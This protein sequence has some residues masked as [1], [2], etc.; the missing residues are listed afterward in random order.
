[1]KKIFLL[2]LLI[3]LV[4]IA[5]FGGGQ[6]ITNPVKWHTSVEKTGENT[7]NLIFEADIEEGWHVYS[8]FN[9]PM[10]S[11]P[12]EFEW[13][14]AKGNYEVIGKAKE[15]NTHK[16][17]NK[18]FKVTETFFSK[19]AKLSQ[20]IKLINKNLKNIKV[21][22]F[23]QTCK[24]SCI[25]I[26]EKLSFDLSKAKDVSKAKTDTNTT[27]VKPEKKQEPKTDTSNKNSTSSQTEAPKENN[28]NDKVEATNKTDETVN[29][30]QKDIT[31]GGKY[32][33][34]QIAK[35]N[36]QQEEVATQETNDSAPEKKSD[37]SIFWTA[38]IAGLLVLLTPCVFPMIPLTISFFTKQN[39]NSSKGK[40]N[41]LVYAF[42]IV[43][44]Y[45]AVSLP[46]HLLEKADS[47]IFN[48][49]AT[50]TTVNLVF[51]TIFILFALNLFGVEKLDPMRLVPNSWVS[52]AD[53]R[54]NKGGILSGFFMALTLVIVSFSCTGP[55]LG[56]ILGNAASGASG[57]TSLTFALL[58]FGLGI[59]IPFGVLAFF[60]VLLQKL[61]QSGAWLNTVKVIFG[62]IELAFAFKFLSNADLVNQWHFLHRELFIAIWV[63]ISLVMAMYLFG[64]I[65][66][67]HDAPVENISVFR[68][69]FGTSILIFAIYLLPG[70]WG[71]PLNIISG[72]PPPMKYAESKFGV[73]N[74][75]RAKIV[76]SQN[77]ANHKLPEGAEYGPNNIVTFEDYDLA[78]AHAKEVNKPLL[79]DFTGRACQNCR[80]MEENVWSK[81][82][83][84]PILNNEVVLVSLFVDE[85]TELPKD[86]QYISK[87]TGDKVTTVGK[88]WSEMET[89]VYKNNS[90]PLY[91][92]VDHDEKI[93]NKN[94]IGYTPEV[95]K[96]YEWLRKGID[97]FNKK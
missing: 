34:I 68:F 94:A 86:K 59:A 4:S 44:I 95:E 66:L 67:P 88:K 56:F 80:L 61:P 53:K 70:M 64:K 10:G 26:E 90:L 38:F 46:F 20:A 25:Q 47:S 85:R 43:L 22:L 49:I 24:E 51:F 72:F 9:D 32:T 36:N 62:F 14:D 2:F 29:K 65:R 63:G 37:W 82:Q 23:G 21:T 83:I 7:Y 39:E 11:L 41:A 79:I 55:A 76:Q 96:Y 40:F 19:H 18:V 74:T 58:G 17:Y 91:V 71:A 31:E 30:T 87:Y 28:N 1:M 69:L 8:Q 6:G 54:S 27:S 16:E 97:E 12:I 93:M 50:N 57:A 52:S 78:M 75:Q 84:L 77:S 3:P 89:F 73:G 60:P 42:S 45:V 81:D 13:K 33:P 48:N 15:F 5:Q 35:N 92:I